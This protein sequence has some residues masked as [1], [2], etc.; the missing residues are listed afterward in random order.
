MTIKERA[1]SQLG[2]AHRLGYTH[3]YMTAPASVGEV[4]SLAHDWFELGQRRA[5]GAEFVSGPEIR[6]LMRANRKTIA[7]LAGVMGITQVRVRY[8]R[9]A[10]IT[11]AGF[12]QDWLEA[13][14]D[15]R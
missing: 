4:S 2:S 5:I 9:A 13:I 1:Q 8:V 10:G 15:K 11:G 3:P 12:V 7:G 14:G 6:R